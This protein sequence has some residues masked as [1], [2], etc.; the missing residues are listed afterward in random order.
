MRD[1]MTLSYKQKILSPKK[2][3]LHD[4]TVREKPQR[5]TRMHRKAGAEDA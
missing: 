3:A 5:K 4:D 1:P 2:F